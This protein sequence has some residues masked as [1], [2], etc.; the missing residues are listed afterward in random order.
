MRR[1]RRHVKRGPRRYCRGRVRRR[2][3]SLHRRRK[4]RPRIHRLQRCRVRRGI[5][6]L[7]VRGIPSRMSKMRWVEKHILC[8][9][10]R[11]RREGHRRTRCLYRHIRIRRRRGIG[12][13]PASGK[14]SKTRSVG[15]RWGGVI[16]GARIAC[17]A[18][19]CRSCLDLFLFFLLTP[20]A[21]P[22]CIASCQSGSVRSGSVHVRR[23]PSDVSVG[24]A[25]RL[26]RSPHCFLF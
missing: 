11:R 4:R 18:V 16:F 14:P 1:L 8:G 22:P 26:L 20:L 12:R 7:S 10:R 21:T 24:M 2:R 9:C 15:K 6:R 5:E 25:S 19:V 23:A 3:S 13:R 17:C